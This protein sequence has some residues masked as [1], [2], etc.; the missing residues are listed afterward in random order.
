LSRHNILAPL[1]VAPGARE[2]SNMM[3]VER[4]ALLLIFPIL[5]MNLQIKTVPCDRFPTSTDFANTVRM[6][7]KV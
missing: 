1:H 4:M 3:D 6:M 5:Q 7:M 2:G